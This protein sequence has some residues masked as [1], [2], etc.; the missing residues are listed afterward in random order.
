VPPEIVVEEFRLSVCDPDWSKQLDGNGQAVPEPRGGTGLARSTRVRFTR[1]A[2]IWDGLR[3]S[4][5]FIPAVMATAAAALGLWLVTSATGTTVASSGGFNWFYGGD[6]QGAR[7]VL[8][9]VAGSII[10]VVSITFTIT[11]VILTLTAQQFGPRLLRTFFHDSGTKV[12]LGTLLGTF[13]Y[14]LVVL[15]SIQGDDASTFVP[16]HAVTGGV[17]LGIASIGAL[18]YFI[19]HIAFSIQASAL[20]ER[21]SR[22]LHGAIDRLFPT[23][24]GD[25]PPEPT[26]GEPDRRRLASLDQRSR[27]IES[28]SEGYVQRVN[29]GSLLEAA[30]GPDLVVRVLARPG[31]FVRRGGTLAEAVPPG[32]VSE[33]AAA[34]V[35][36]AFLVG[37]G[38]TEVQDA[39]FAIEQLVEIAV[40]AL[41]PAINDPF[42][43]MT[44][45]DRLG[46]AL[47][48]LAGREPPSPLRFDPDGRLRVVAPPVSFR[49]AADRAFSAICR[50]AQSE[51]LVLHRVVRVLTDLAEP[52]APAS[53]RAALA[54]QAGLVHRLVQ[55]GTLDERDRRRLD[56]DSRR[57]MQRAAAVGAGA[58]ADDARRAG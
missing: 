36:A 55:S 32:A 19:H 11:I 16:A 4:F 51:P 54:E 15:R 14:S 21:V 42:T 13:V 37:R 22:E 28:R 56:R 17:A 27:R 53:V 46:A 43:A 44:C 24:L 50:H 9:T 34:R 40:R 57:A 52:S 8:S 41:S 18:I 1:L 33:A 20:V 49:E 29:D 26:L 48:A 38:Q 30:K 45:V 5:W 3:S 35:A 39:L 47:G 12:V 2:A 10:T 31:E 25:R 7:A 58:T 23:R 6:A